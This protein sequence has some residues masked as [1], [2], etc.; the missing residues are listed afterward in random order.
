[1]NITDII[2]L[3]LILFYAITGWN[4]GFF[5]TILGPLVVIVCCILAW[6]YFKSTHN[7]VISFAI[8]MAGPMMINGLISWFLTINDG[9]GE[10]KTLLPLS[11]FLGLAVSVT[12]G[13]TISL[14]IV[15][16]LAMSPFKLP[17]Q[18]VRENILQSQTFALVS[19]HIE[20][21]LPLSP[22]KSNHV[23]VAKTSVK[24][25]SSRSAA[26]NS[27]SAPSSIE[28]SAE[29]QA[30]FNDS[31]VKELYADP[32]VAELIKKQDYMALIQ[33]PKFTQ[34]LEDPQLVA[35][36][37]QLKSKISREQAPEGSDSHQENTNE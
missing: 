16:L 26:K 4:K 12:W 17:V 10:K 15:L 8:S 18:G 5:R 37:I 23:A 35:Q 7:V 14:F 27:T 19:P 6:M 32:E 31:R 2:I 33:N 11:R 24:T 25:S 13:V 28:N 21:F 3:L 22:K 36:M 9:G 20:S 1:M 29:Y 30:V 34:I